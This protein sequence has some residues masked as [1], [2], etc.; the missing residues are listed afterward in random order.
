MTIYVQ[1]PIPGQNDQWTI[2]ATYN[3][4][5]GIAYTTPEHQILDVG[6]TFVGFTKVNTDGTS[7]TQVMGFYPDAKGFLPGVKSHGIIQDDSGHPYN[8]SYATNVT[9]TQFNAALGRVVTD[10]ANANYILSNGQAPYPEYNCTDAALTWM[11]TASLQIPGNV[12]RGAFDNTPGDYG[13][14]LRS[15]NGANTAKSTAPSGHGACN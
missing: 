13:Q 10:N 14:A 3:G 12:A 11:S 9:A 6:H 15:F 2:T 8:V 5:G 1:Q 7:V 4:F